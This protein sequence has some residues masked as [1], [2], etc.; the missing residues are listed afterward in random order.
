MSLNYTPLR[1]KMLRA[2]ADH[3]GDLGPVVYCANQKRA[4][5][6]PCYFA[7]QGIEQ[8]YSAAESRAVMDLW[9]ADLLS[10]PHWQGDMHVYRL[11]YASDAGKAQLAEWTSQHREPK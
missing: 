9:N 7:D 11:L 10:T 8:H 4:I 3:A 2:V 1:H 5:W 6:R